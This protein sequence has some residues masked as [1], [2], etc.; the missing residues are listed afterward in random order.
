MLSEKEFNQIK[1]QISKTSLTVRQQIHVV[2]ELRK[3]TNFKNKTSAIKEYL[4]I[5]S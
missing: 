2:G 3:I 5:E 4:S 1:N